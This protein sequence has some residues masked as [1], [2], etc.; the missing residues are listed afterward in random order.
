MYIRR[1]S[2]IRWFRLNVHTRSFTKVCYRLP[3][4]SLRNEMKKLLQFLFKANWLSE[5]MIMFFFSCITDPTLHWIMGKVLAPYS[6]QL[7]LH[8]RTFFYPFNA[9]VVC[10]SEHL[11]MAV[12]LGVQDLITCPHLAL[13]ARNESNNLAIN[14]H[15]HLFISEAKQRKCNYVRITLN[16]RDAPQGCSSSFKWQSLTTAALW[17]KI[18][19]D[20]AS[21]MFAV[22]LLG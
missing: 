19:P 5:N 15:K 7:A 21:I 14:M 16:F 3:W 2:S 1:W 6:H 12:A 11:S 22:V 10:Y 18:N 13:N 17:R 4:L 20:D 9:I 8:R